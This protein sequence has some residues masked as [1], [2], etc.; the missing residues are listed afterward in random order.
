MF[1]THETAVRE[2]L[3]RVTR[4]RCAIG[5]H[6][7]GCPHRPTSNPVYSALI[8]GNIVT[9]NLSQKGSKVQA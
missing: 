4:Q 2:A 7:L 6:R 9:V 1:V 5:Q 3:E 8:G